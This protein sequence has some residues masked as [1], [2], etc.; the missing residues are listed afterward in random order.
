VRGAPI[1]DTKKKSVGVLE[2]LSKGQPKPV[3]DINIEKSLQKRIAV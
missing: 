1:L 3:L 2:G